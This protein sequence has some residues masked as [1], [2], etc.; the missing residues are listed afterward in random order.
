MERICFVIM[1]FSETNSCTKRQWTN[2]YTSLFKK[3]VEEAGLGYECRRSTATRGS[4]IKGIIGDLDSSYVVL[5][6]LTDQN[7]NV[8]YELGIRHALRPR[9]ILIAQDR[10]N[11]PFDLREYASHIYDWRTPAGRRKFRR[12]IVDILKDIDKDSE[13]SDNPVSDFLVRTSTP[14]LQPATR[15]EISESG[16]SIVGPG[17]SELNISGI[18]KQ[19]AEEN[20]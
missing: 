8:F 1:P 18:V 3:T 16:L 13:R 20:R 4:I 5:A 7:P 19:M 12:V 10:T 14:Q 15:S 17:T 9:T 6:D 2:I 11:I